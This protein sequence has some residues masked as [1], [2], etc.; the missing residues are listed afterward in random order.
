[1]TSYPQDGTGYAHART[2]YGSGT[3][4]YGSGGGVF[5]NGESPQFVLLL[6]SFIS[7]AAGFNYDH[8]GYNYSD[9]MG[10]AAYTGGRNTSQQRTGFPYGRN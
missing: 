7:I 4:P 10:G 6:L 9:Q 3:E 8:T 1:M 5:A 2:G